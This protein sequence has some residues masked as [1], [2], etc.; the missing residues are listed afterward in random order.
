MRYEPVDDNYLVHRRL[1]RSAGWGLLWALGVGAVISG[2]FL[3]WNFGLEVGGFGG[4]AIATLLMAIMYICLV[5]SLAE[6]SCEWII[7][8]F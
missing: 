8:N 7:Q 5:Y 3:G 6:L 2:S 4:L 1:K